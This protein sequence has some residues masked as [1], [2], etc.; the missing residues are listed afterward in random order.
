ML[1]LIYSV[2]L[3]VSVNYIHVVYDHLYKIRAMAGFIDKPVY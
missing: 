1:Y 3:L 2:C